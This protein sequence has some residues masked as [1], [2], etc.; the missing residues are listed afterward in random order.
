MTDKKSTI[1]SSKP[2]DQDYK[3]FT[4]VC[5][6]EQDPE[7]TILRVHLLVEYYL[8][9]FIT[10]GLDRGDKITSQG[11]FSFAQKIYIVEALNL[12]K[13]E[14]IQSIKNLNKVRNNCAHELHKAISASDVELI[15]RPFGKEFTKIRHEHRYDINEFL[16]QTLMILCA[17]LS[18]SIE[19][20]EKKAIKDLAE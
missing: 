12:V 10:M 9:K 4:S 18:G 1:Q 7:L 13:D 16:Y 20:V 15:G 17:S 19:C 8:E 11:N 3:D 6:I 2:E 5:R 14:I